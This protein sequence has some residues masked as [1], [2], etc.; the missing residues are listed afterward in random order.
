LFNN[1]AHNGEL[2]E[3][4]SP[5]WVKMLDEGYPNSKLSD[6]VMQMDTDLNVA[7][8]KGTG[9]YSQ[10]LGQ[11]GEEYMRDHLRQKGFEVYN[12]HVTV[13]VGDD[14]RY[15][16]V[17]Y[18]SQG[19]KNWRFM[20]VKVNGSM[21]TQR[22]VRVDRQMLREGV[23]NVGYKAPLDIQFNTPIRMEMGRIIND[24]FKPQP[25]HLR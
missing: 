10:K 22:Q 6:L 3:V 24:S 14:I 4:G 21:P 17:A 7:A 16:D 2:V 11:S 18:R 23:T 8:E 25:R 5:E 19:E 15:V 20:E 9:F 12:G 13:Y 1:E